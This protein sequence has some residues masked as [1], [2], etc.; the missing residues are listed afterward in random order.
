MVGVVQTILTC[1]GNSDILQSNAIAVV[2]LDTVGDIADGDI[3][4]NQLVI[5]LGNLQETIAI[6]GCSA[7]LNNNVI[8]IAQVECIGIQ[9]LA[10]KVTVLNG[11]SYNNGL[12]GLGNLALDKVDVLDG[13]IAAGQGHGTGVVE[14]SAVDGQF[15]VDGDI[16][17]D[18]SHQSDGVA[19]SGCGDGLCQSCVA[20]A[21]DLSNAALRNSAVI[22]RLGCQDVQGHHAHDHH[23]G[24]RHSQQS[25]KVNFHCFH[26][27]PFS[28][29]REMSCHK[30]PRRH[31]CIRS[32]AAPSPGTETAPPPTGR[33]MPLFTF[34]HFAFFAESR[35]PFLC[36]HRRAAASGT[37]AVCRFRRL[38]CRL[39]RKPRRGSSIIP[40]SNV[41]GSHL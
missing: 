4:H 18:V 34:V 8:D 29:F 21:I 24:K 31:R 12:V 2:D 10:V 27:F 40:G 30:S 20:H 32:S 5:G 39:G 17:F 28:G 36:T 22:A 16:L 13:N 15:L 26:S 3:L 38:V 19:G 25:L 41:G 1:I 37:D 6:V 33:R 9:A 14:L 35:R 23:D 7:V 11:N